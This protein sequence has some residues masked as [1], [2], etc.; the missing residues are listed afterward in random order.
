M[1]RALLW[2]HELEIIRLNKGLA[3][4][5][6]AMTIKLGGDWKRGFGNREF[7]PLELHYQDRMLQ[8]H[9]MEEYAQRGIGEIADALAL[10]MDYFEL[11]QEAFLARWLPE[12]E[13]EISRQM[14]SES[15][16]NIV[17]SLG[18]PEQKRIVTDKRE[19]TSA[20]VLA[21]PVPAR[22][23]CSFTASPGCCGRGASGRGALS[24]WLTTAMRR[25]TSGGVC[26]TWSATTPGAL[27]L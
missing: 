25:R 24:H 16:R 22:P 13:A 1:E 9:V 4:F 12:K 15:W 18:N 19:K 17:E 3:V 26:G 2:L 20:L 6:P 10:A 27:R 7:E 5:R 11:E 23:G 14:T 8:I 21:G